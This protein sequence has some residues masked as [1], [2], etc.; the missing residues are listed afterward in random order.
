M[1]ILIQRICIALSGL[2]SFKNVEMLM[3]EIA[4]MLLHNKKDYIFQEQ[5][6]VL[7]T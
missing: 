5:Q 1:I 4:A 6:T 3:S 2:G 7:S